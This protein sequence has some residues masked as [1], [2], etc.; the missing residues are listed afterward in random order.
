M[1]LGS[2]DPKRSQNQAFM[3]AKD[4]SSFYVLFI[5][6]WMSMKKW[7]TVCLP[8]SFRLIIYILSKGFDKGIDILSID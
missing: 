4:T 1:N 5:D 3:N 8:H 7:F 6:G 2:I